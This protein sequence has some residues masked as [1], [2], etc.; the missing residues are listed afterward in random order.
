MYASRI[1]ISLVIEVAIF[2][3][4]IFIYVIWTR[5]SVTLFSHV[6]IEIIERNLSRS[7]AFSNTKRVIMLIYI[8]KILILQ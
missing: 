8:I 5:L 4:I 7:E 6:L 2:S 1:C 3:F